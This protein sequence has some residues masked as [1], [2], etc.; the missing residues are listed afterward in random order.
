MVCA[1]AVAAARQTEMKPTTLAKNGPQWFLLRTRAKQERKVADALQAKGYEVFLPMHTVR[2]QWSDRL[3]TYDAPLFPGY[4]FCRFSFVLENKN[5]MVL[6]TPGVVLIYPGGEVPLP[7]PD[8]E[9]GRLRRV[10]A[11][12]YPV[13]ACAFPQTGEVVEIPGDPTIRGVLVERGSPCRVAVGFDAMGRTVVLRIP[14]DDLKRVDG[15]LT[16]HWSLRAL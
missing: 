6:K 1:I 16:P 4:L 15:P 9:I 8:L 14:L 7:I 5:L 10:T 12:Q 13:E 3:K 2:R 11:S